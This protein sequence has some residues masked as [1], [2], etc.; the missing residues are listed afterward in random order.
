[1]MLN[2]AEIVRGK[3]NPNTSEYEW[4]LYRLLL[5]FSGV[6]CEVLN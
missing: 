5:R 2:F 3:E 4:G 1:M 6:Q